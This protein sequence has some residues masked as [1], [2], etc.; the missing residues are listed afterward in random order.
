MRQLLKSHWINDHYLQMLAWMRNTALFGNNYLKPISAPS[1]CILYSKLAPNGVV[2]HMTAAFKVIH[3][4]V[5]DITRLFDVTVKA[6]IFSSI[7]FW[8]PGCLH[9]KKIISY[10]HNYSL[11]EFIPHSP[12]SLSCGIC[13]K[14]LLCNTLLTF[15]CSIRGVLFL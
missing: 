11:R 14:L 7:S 4:Y 15:N 6:F 13:F 3:W 2:V 1:F 9:L 8:F 12:L 10:Y 5:T